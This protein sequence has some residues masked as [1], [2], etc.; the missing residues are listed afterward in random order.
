[1]YE[2]CIFAFVLL[3][4]PFCLNKKKVCQQRLLS[5]TSIPMSRL[6][7]LRPRLDAVASLLRKES[8]AISCQFCMN[9]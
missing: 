1:M 3:L 2:S 7:W 6:A 5:E 8:N 4:H 9:P